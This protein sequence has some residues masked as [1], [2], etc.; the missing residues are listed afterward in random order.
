DGRPDEMWLKQIRR[1]R[2]TRPLDAIILMVD[3][4]T[5]LPDAVRGTTSPWGIHLARITHLL[6]WSAPVFV[7][8]LDGTDTVHRVDTP[9][10]GCEIPHAADA[11]AI[12]TALLE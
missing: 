3:E 6:R 4:S 7:L 9:V 8:D 2:R 5:L 1:F 10:T 12:E 11:P